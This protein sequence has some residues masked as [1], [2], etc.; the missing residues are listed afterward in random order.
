MAASDQICKAGLFQGVRDMAGTFSSWGALVQ[1]LQQEVADATEEVIKGSLEDLRKNVDG[2]YG[3]SGGRYQRT[4]TLRSSPEGSFS[5]GG[6][7]SSGEI[8]L[9]TGHAYVPAGR[10]TVTI[11][12]YEEDGGLRGNGGFWARTM[13]EVPKHIQDSFGKRFK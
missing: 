3:S 10:D 1:A 6:S 7:V 5:G 11:Y 13:M 12:N 4:R 2:F 9:N 8:R